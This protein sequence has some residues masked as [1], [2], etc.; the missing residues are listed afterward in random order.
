MP[1]RETGVSLSG[2]A[3]SSII[4]CAMLRVVTIV[5][6]LGQNGHA[7]RMTGRLKS[8]W[9]RSHLRKCDGTK[10]VVVASFQ[11]RASIEIADKSIT[12]LARGG[13]EPA[14][15]L[16]GSFIASNRSKRPNIYLNLS[17]LDSRFYFSF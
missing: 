13:I 8:C 17:D 9:V 1:T 16:R 7:R 4:V 2:P 12:Y 11:S 5:L 6:M 10:F 3:K 14:V 15:A